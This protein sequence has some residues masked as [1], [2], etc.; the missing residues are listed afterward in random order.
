MTD[1][2][3][4]A[5]WYSAQTAVTTT[6]LASERFTVRAG[7]IVETRLTFDRLGHVPQG[8]KPG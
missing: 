7:Q 8:Q 5:L 2:D 4:V 3:R 1:R 6:T